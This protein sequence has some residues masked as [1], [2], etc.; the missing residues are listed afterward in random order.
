MWPTL[1]RH[2]PLASVSALLDLSGMSEC[3]ADS[4]IHTLHSNQVAELVLSVL[5]CEMGATFPGL[6]KSFCK[7]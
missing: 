7:I 6:R 1:C 2:M 4:K 5:S 3:I